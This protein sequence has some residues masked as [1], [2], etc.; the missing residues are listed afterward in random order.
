MRTQ[1]GTLW[2]IFSSIV[3]L[4]V[5]TLL[6]TPLLV[7][8]EV[9]NDAYS[10]EDSFEDTSG[11]NLSETAGFE[12]SGGALQ[13]VASPAVAVSESISLP[14]PEGGTFLGWSFLKINLSALGTSS[15]TL[16]VQDCSGSTLLTINA[17]PEG[18][19]E[20]DLSGISEPAIRL[21]WTVGQVGAKLNFWN[22]YGTADGATCIDVFPDSDMVNAGDTVTFTISLST[23]GAM[24]RNPVLRFSLDDINGLHTPGVDDGLAED[25]EVDYG[26]GNGVV[27]Y[28]PLE[29]VFSSSGP[30]GELPVNE[31]A[32]GETSG[33]VVWN[34]NNLSDGFSDNVVVILRV[35]QG[36]IN[37]K[38]LAARAMLEHG[39]SSVIYT[40]MMSVIETS[41]LVTVNS[42]ASSAQL[43]YTNYNNLG[44]GAT[45]IYDA[46]YVRGPLP[47]PDTNP[48]DLEDIT[49]TITGIGTCFPL[50]KSVDVRFGSDFQIV[51]TPAV[52]KPITGSDPV[53]V[54]FDRGDFHHYCIWIYIYYDVPGTCSE[55][56]TIGTQSEIVVG[57]PSWTDTDSQLHNVVF[58]TCRR[59]TNHVHRV[60][61]GNDPGNYL[62]WPGWTE[63]YIRYGS[64]RTGEYFTSWMP[65]GN[66]GWR[67]HTVPLDHSYDLI[68]IPAGIT[69]HGIRQY[70]YLSQLYKDCTGTA[71]APTD[72]AFNHNTDPPHTVW[73]PVDIAWYGAP[74][75]NPPDENDSRGV[76]L[77][78]CR[79][80]GVKD[81]DNPAWQGPDNGIWR[82]TSLWRMCD[83]TYGCSEL[84]EGTVM[85]LIGGTI[86]TYETVTNPAGAAHE[87][88]TYNGWPLYKELK[89]WPKVYGW[90]EENQVPAGQVAH[91]ILNPENQNHA[92]QWVD[93]RWVVNLYA[94]REYI[95]LTGITGEV[96]T[97]GLNIPAPDQNVLGQSCIAE[98]D[99][100][101]NVPDPIGCSSAVNEDDSACMAWW[102]VPPA[103]QP[104]NGWG[105]P[106]PGNYANDDFVP[107]YRFRLN[108][109]ILNTTPANTVLDF[110][111]EVRVND[112]TVRGADNAVDPVRWPV[113]N[114]TA[115]TSVTVLE[116]PGLDITK[117]GPVA[118][119]LGDTITYTLEATNYGNSP[120]DGWYLVDW[121]PREGVNSSQFTLEYGKVYMNQM[122][123]DIIVEYSLDSGCFT[124][125]LGGTWTAVSL[126]GTT[127]TGYQSET[128]SNINPNAT[129]LRLRRNPST[130]MHFNPGDTLL[131]A[132]DVVIPNDGSLDSKW[133]YNR[134]LGS[135]AMV[136][137]APSDVS[138]VETVNIRT[139]VSSQVAV[140]IDKTFELDYIRAG[141]I[142][143]KLLVH[144]TSGAI[145]SNISVI[146]NLPN[147]IIYE[148]LA[149]VLPPGWIYVEEPSIGDINGELRIMINELSPDDGNPGTGEDEGFITFW[150]RV[151]EGT[152]IGTLIQN[153]AM[154]TPEYGTGDG[155]CASIII[156]DLGVNKVQE[157]IDRIESTPITDVIPL[158]II[159]YT[160][161]VTDQ[162]EFPISIRIYDLLDIYV[163]YL[164]GTFTVNGATA[165]DTFFSGG[166]LD[167]QY[168]D[169]LNPGETL[170]LIFEVT[171]KDNAPD[172]W[173]IENKA[174][175]SSCSDP[176]DPYSCFSTIE[177]PTVYDQLFCDETDNDGDGFS[178]CRRDCDDADPNVNPGAI[179]ICDGED[180]NCNGEI[181][182]G[183]VCDIS[184]DLDGDNDVDCDDYLKFGDSFGLCTNELNY[185]PEADPDG[186]GCVTVSDR[187]ILYPS[188]LR[189]CDLACRSK[190]DKIQLTWMHVGADSYK[191]YRKLEGQDYSLLANITSTYSTYLD[192]DVSIGNTYYYLV[193]CICNDVEGE[194]S[195]E[196]NITLTVTR[197]R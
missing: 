158:D 59:G 146:D 76:A 156:P 69:F 46:P 126:Q 2:H 62:L 170:S 43:M 132:I 127:R 133:I 12:V 47:L 181:D 88:F 32:F 4:M 52:G 175:I 165:S 19:S 141:W 171:V 104:P 182:E 111:G 118:K 196:T 13:A 80:L 100:I 188:C 194:V 51:S 1:K 63:Y 122:P 102:E 189:V 177:T 65:Y 11:L 39:I 57:N 178:L 129:C 113:N 152:P 96:L 42:M 21:M 8:A 83:G 55:G 92:S 164:P 121:L 190:R 99:I 191:I 81:N 26:W 78:G 114:Y 169:L 29:F 186:D 187:N 172:S 107:M 161:T 37:G 123:E 54:H 183:D 30:N 44:P 136:F 142:K 138:H 71:P 89:S 74:F 140:E 149:E 108:V 94:I 77:P 105:N 3:V 148:G 120:N 167:Y 86:F 16:E 91:I 106:I 157:A 34:L 36:Y 85:S 97:D 95:D 53:I 173:I 145:A 68:E 61:R 41:S 66:E 109:P 14:Q 159:K 155:S 38:S 72:P 160:I 25:A 17:L 60:M 192:Y 79:L 195:N 22:I 93:G 18:E 193:K 31:P 168:P 137:G 49:V 124:N 24:A 84:A 33:E 184:G 56:D 67:I 70:N 40:N 151:N 154:A 90:P 143:W 135:A 45:N 150:S 128:V 197:T 73:K 115:S 185:L 6:T 153:C 116:L 130:T 9:Y 125:P 103:C 20:I 179:E 166:E 35:P 174:Q 131:G 139:Q 110:I 144:N 147:E 176:L 58:E 119:K 82:V 28:R 15:N 27:S 98:D 101:F 10:Y 75:S 134:A 180:N 5:I 112:L 163:D 117:A 87:C 23:S 64:L 162:L 50:F 48:S 7:H